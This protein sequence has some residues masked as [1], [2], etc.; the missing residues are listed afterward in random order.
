[1]MSYRKK[2]LLGF[3]VI[4]FALMI[5]LLVLAAMLDGVKQNL[6]EIMDERYDKVSRST[7]FR[8]SFSYLDSEV[9]YL[10]NENDPQ[11]ISSHLSEIERRIQSAYNHLS[12]LQLH[13]GKDGNLPM[14]GSI[15]QGLDRYMSVFEQIDQALDQGNTEAAAT[16]F[17]E[18]AQ[19]IRTNLLR[20]LGEYTTM[21]ENRMQ[22][23]Q[24]E[25]DERFEHILIV[26]GISALAIILIGVLTAMWVIRGTSRSLRKIADRMDTFDPGAIEKMSRVT[27]DTDD[28]IGH[29]A[30][31]YNHMLDALEEHNRQSKAFN[32]HIE[33]NNWL[34]T[35]LNQLVVL[36]P[37]MTSQDEL[38]QNFL[39]IV[40]PSVQ[41]CSGHF[42]IREKKNDQ[43]RFVTVASYADTSS[44]SKRKRFLPG[45]G[46]IGQAAIDAREILLDFPEGNQEDLQVGSGT[47][48]P[49]QLWI[50]PIEADERVEAV[51]ELSSLQVFSPLHRQL[52]EQLR[53]TLGIALQS[54][55]G[56]SEVE[57]LLR[58]SQL[59]AEELRRSSQYKSEFLA[60]MSHELR[61]P[62]NSILILS[63]LIAENMEEESGESKEYADIIH[64]SGEDL[65]NIVNDVL[66]LSKVEAGML[67][68]NREAFPLRD[69][70]ELI[71]YGFDTL[72]KQKNIEFD[73]KLSDDIPDF[74]YTDGKRLQQIVKN[75]LSNAFKFTATGKVSCILRSVQV[76]DI[77]C[78][79]PISKI[80]RSCIAITV[81][82]TGI[83]IAED[84]RELIFEAFRQADGSTERMYGGTGLGLSI[85]RQFAKL[86]G[87]CMTLESIE[88]KGS[89]FT[90][91]MPE[92]PEGSG[93]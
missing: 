18:E 49:R 1:M 55:S 59:L 33:D 3:G 47:F 44:P 32:R 42:Y 27:V 54:V 84:K 62:L 10:I 82:D 69:F 53:S 90:L 36:Y 51:L 7:A 74:F 17:I 37:Q 60:N 93:D 87:G 85:C 14:L 23:A 15:Q 40:A 70:P 26:S 12:Y 65:L 28:E 21:Q 38:A 78:Q 86:L 72:A 29:I 64:R 89:S 25:A 41:A 45:E 81:E 88:G 77:P 48:H 20:N 30:N 61:T 13:I 24:K 68:I 80:E 57:R 35:K 56:R 75:L 39:S 71:H 2:Q 22:M 66:D 92:L 16:L 31:G 58:E 19:S 50:I 52:I 5:L 63:Q 43:I 34:Q 76:S 83:G 79:M 9:G 91:Y 73:I 8:T 6:S 46:L 67:D 11:Q 4:L